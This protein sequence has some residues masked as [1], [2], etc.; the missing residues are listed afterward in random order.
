[1]QDKYMTFQEK[2]TDSYYY[3]SEKDL[4]EA[5]TKR[6]VIHYSQ[7]VWG[8]AQFWIHIINSNANMKWSKF[9]MI[10]PKMIIQ[11]LQDNFIRCQEMSNEEFLMQYV[12]GTVSRTITFVYN[13]K[14]KA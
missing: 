9:P 10:H 2:E 12:L 14:D 5:L 11:M 7:F 3:I 4:I 6:K 1:M 8:P 13:R